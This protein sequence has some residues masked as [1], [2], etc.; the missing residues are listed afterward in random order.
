MVRV[1]GRELPASGLPGSLTFSLGKG[2]RA[3]RG[4][5]G[6]EGPGA[7]RGCTMHVLPCHCP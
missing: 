4:S 5:P 7:T 2:Q 1:A 3:P 6:E